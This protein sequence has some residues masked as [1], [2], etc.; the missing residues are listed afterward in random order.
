VEVLLQQ[1][2]S[3]RQQQQLLHAA[4]QQ[5][6]A[7]AAA[8]AVRRQQLAAQVE[9]LQALQ[10]RHLQHCEL[11]GAVAGE[12]GLCHAERGFRHASPQPRAHCPRLA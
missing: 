2:A 1:Q 3:E 12:P 11:L 6:Q 5:Q 8:A 10:G 7:A 9:T 4:R